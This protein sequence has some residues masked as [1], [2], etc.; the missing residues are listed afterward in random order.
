MLY[1]H[2]WQQIASSEG[3]KMSS[4]V[5]SHADCVQTSAGITKE[6]EKPQMIGVNLRAEALLLYHLKLRRGTLHAAGCS[7][8]FQA[9]FSRAGQERRKIWSR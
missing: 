1:E 7:R 2:E 6:R 8:N 4:G 5:S 9:V 3:R